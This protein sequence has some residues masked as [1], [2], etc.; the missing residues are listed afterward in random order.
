MR[1]Y[2]FWALFGYILNLEVTAPFDSDNVAVCFRGNRAGV[3]TRGGH[4]AN[5][6]THSSRNNTK[7]EAQVIIGKRD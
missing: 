1:Y 3:S 6:F 5:N 2:V 4:T 7:E